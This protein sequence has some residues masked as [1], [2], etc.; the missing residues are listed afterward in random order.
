[1][2][3]FHKG[4]EVEVWGG[5]QWHKAKIV[6]GSLIDDDT[7]E[8]EFLGSRF[9]RPT[10][11]IRKRQYSYDSKC[12]EVAAWFLVNRDAPEYLVKELAQHIQDEIEGWFSFNGERIE[13]ATVAEQEGGCESMSTEDQ[14]YHMTTEEATRECALQLR[15]ITA[16]LAS[17]KDAR[18]E[19]L[20]RRLEEMLRL[21]AEKDRKQRA[22]NS[23]LR[24][25]FMSSA[26][27]R[28][29]NISSALCD[30][31]DKSLEE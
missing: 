5:D 16:A 30:A 11:H 18:I 4:Q 14:I 25:L 27:P 21:F 8:V 19:A 1:M 7:Y 24:E 29:T 17:D 2:A 22:V 15:R 10:R 12:G 13:A 6:G 9:F 23:A 26:N 28:A 3:E 31:L 20:D